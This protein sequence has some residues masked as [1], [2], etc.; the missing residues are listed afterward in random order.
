MPGHRS[1]TLLQRLPR[2]LE[3]YQAGSYTSYWDVCTLDYL[4]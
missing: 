2:F 4:R 3:L 1:A